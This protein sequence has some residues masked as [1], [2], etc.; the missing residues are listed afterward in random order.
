MDPSSST[1]GNSSIETTIRTL[2]PPAI[3]P[4]NLSPKSIDSSHSRI[5]RIP[6]KNNAAAF[7]A[8]RAAAGKGPTKLKIAPS[9]TLK[10]LVPKTERK[11]QETSDLTTRIR[12]NDFG[13]L[14]ISK[15]GSQGLTVSKVGNNGRIYL[16][17]DLSLT[18]LFVRPTT[19]PTNQR[20]ASQPATLV[21][22]LGSSSL[23]AQNQN[24]DQDQDQSKTRPEKP[25]ASAP[26]SMPETRP[27]HNM[28]NLESEMEKSEGEKTSDLHLSQWESPSP[29]ILDESQTQPKLRHMRNLSKQAETVL[30]GRR[31]AMS[32]SSFHEMPMSPIAASVAV[33]SEPDGLRIVI[34][35]TNER[36]RTA[37]DG[38]LSAKLDIPI[39]SHRIGLPRFTKRGTPVIRTSCYTA[40]DDLQSSSPPTISI[41]P[42]SLARTSFRSPVS[43]YFHGASREPTWM[44]MQPTHRFLPSTPLLPIVSSLAHLAAAQS[45]P[46]TPAEANML[47]TSGKNSSPPIRSTYMSVHQVIEPSMF[48]A[49]TFKPACD[50]RALVR[51]SPISGSVTAATPPRLVAEITSANF[52]DYELLSDFFLTYRAFLE[53]LDLL[54]M[55]IS[56]FRW[57]AA[58]SDE[59]GMVVRVRTFV[60]L[61]HWILN[62]FIDD[63]IN[64]FELRVSF[65]T[66]VNDLIIDLTRIGKDVAPHIKIVNE[67]KKCWRRICAQ[68]WEGPD[69]DTDTDDLPIAPGGSVGPDEEKQ[70]SRLS[71]LSIATVRRELSH[72]ESGVSRV[73]V[74]VEVDDD[75]QL[76][77]P[78][79]EQQLE[80]KQYSARHGVNPLSIS[81]IDVV[82]CTFPTVKSFQKLGLTASSHSNPVRPATAQQTGQSG[83]FSSAP[84][85]ASAPKGIV[86][87]RV[88]PSHKRAGSVS[89]SLRD[90]S[91]PTVNRPTEVSAGENLFPFSG[92]LVRGDL[93]PPSQAFV[94]DNMPTADAEAQRQTTMLETEQAEMLRPEATTAGLSSGTGP[95]VKK[96][97]GS[98]RRALSTRCNP[99]SH[100]NGHS[101]GHG[102]AASNLLNVFGAGTRMPC[103]RTPVTAVVPNVRTK[104]TDDRPAVRVDLLGVEISEAFKRAV[105]EEVSADAAKKGIRLSAALGGPGIQT[106]SP[107]FGGSDCKIDGSNEDNK[108]NNKNNNN[109]NKNKNKNSNNR[110]HDSHGYGQLP[111]FSPSHLNGSFEDLTR[112]STY[113]FTSGR[114]LTHNRGMSDGAITTGS[115]SIMIINDTAMPFNVMA[116]PNQANLSLNSP[117]QAS[118]ISSVLD[119]G[120][121]NSTNSAIDL[122][123]IHSALQMHGV[124]ASVEAFAEALM[125]KNSDLTPPT[126]PPT[127]NNNNNH[128]SSNNNNNNNNHTDQPRRSSLLLNHSYFVRP[129]TD[130]VPIPPFVPDLQGLLDGGCLSPNEAF[131]S[132]QTATFPRAIELA[133]GMTH[134]TPILDFAEGFD[135]SFSAGFGD[136]SFGPGFCSHPFGLGSAS[137]YFGG[138]QPLPSRPMSDGAFSVDAPTVMQNQSRR[139]SVALQSSRRNSV[140]G[141]DGQSIRHSL[142]PSLSDSISPSFASSLSRISG[143]VPPLRILRRRPAGNLRDAQTVE[144]LEPK[145][146][147]YR[148]RSMTTIDTFTD[149][150]GSSSVYSASQISLQPSTYKDSNN[151]PIT[152]SP[153][154]S[155]PTPSIRPKVSASDDEDA[156]VHK[157]LSLFSTHSSLHLRLRPSLEIELRKLAEIPDDLDNGVETALMKLEGR[158][159]RP[160]S[161]AGP[162]PPNAPRLRKM[163]VTLSQLAI[164]NNRNA[165]K[166]KRANRQ[167]GI[168][169]GRL[170]SP[171]TNKSKISLDSISLSTS[172]LR[173]SFLAATSPNRHHQPRRESATSRDSYASVPML[174]RSPLDHPEHDHDHD[175][176]VL[177]PSHDM[178]DHSLHTLDDD[179][180]ISTHKLTGGNAHASFNM[181]PGK[182]EAGVLT[183]RIRISGSFLDDASE[184][185][186]RNSVISSEISASPEI[187]DLIHTGK[188]ASLR[189]A[190]S[191]GTLSAAIPPSPP[192]SL[193][194]S[195]S[196]KAHS[197]HAEPLKQT[198][199]MF[200]HKP[201]PP[202]PDTTPTT[203]YSHGMH[204][205]Q[206]GPSSPLAPAAT[207][208]DNSKEAAHLPFILAFDS[209]ILAQ[210]FTL[211]EKDALIEIDWRELVEM[212][213]K[214]T[215]AGSWRSWLDFLRNSDCHGVEVVVARFNIMVKWA[216]SEI[217]LT[218][219]LEERARCIIKFI[220][221]AK[222]CRRYRN[223]ATLAQITMAL[224]AP[225]VTRLTKTW[226]RVP[227]ADVRIVRDL[228]LLMTPTRNFY[229][230][231]AE[232]ETGSDA[233]CIP[234]VGIYTH[235]LIFNAQR[236]SEIASSPTTG[237]LVNFERYRCAAAVVKTLLRLLEASSLYAFQPIEG[238][239]ERCLW[240]CALSDAELRRRAAKME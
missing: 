53:P 3:T 203:T 12:K 47:S 13:R 164:G 121:V 36:P 33:P 60:A 171:P 8:K 120:A 176:S 32:D 229:N 192:V 106:H 88:R 160:D 24:Q 180:S 20:Y 41:P 131:R 102:N 96:I 213:W 159:Q 193:Q 191:A 22:P 227:A 4:P 28:L 86:G 155:E 219:R 57:A 232:M 128:N 38:P 175:N 123:R 15:P 67:L 100:G 83:G 126:T 204:S 181:I 119:L 78:E 237:P 199:H 179:E 21:A 177:T 111:L 137:Q 104:Q 168:G 30:Q 14:D 114:R 206:S 188:P 129:Q 39:P 239:T 66:L 89:D 45:E 107:G 91:E 81:S 184:C 99:N 68:F 200:A 61:R 90:H 215:T 173:E 157:K 50:D 218:Q 136:Q 186:D 79:L 230:L 197:P 84:K 140:H 49:L 167:I 71:R 236:P 35:Q 98:M 118:G 141:A 222:H 210:Q 103:N 220:H 133:L 233:G 74:E 202:T 127:D 69:F 146:S 165:L 34:S 135:Q 178:T 150:V 40:T 54:R 161:P 37:E 153:S 225:E 51:Y 235:D 10:P 42:P 92:S 87:K 64:D 148:S 56:R 116:L 170:I 80:Q 214:N 23:D 152:L 85:I 149:T 18:K 132:P 29:T 52:L 9:A 144:D 25:P 44:M 169:D 65:C 2:Q 94:D 185:D 105:H 209:D 43:T 17:V 27:S 226:S 139:Q 205:P 108:N 158:Y 196:V 174:D 172:P 151:H 101:N 138:T 198:Q 125:V 194:R 231:R 143:T 224:T 26:I 82:S 59:T 58:R 117:V 77:Q 93:F 48:D 207:D 63:Y 211:I 16:R 201:L 112:Q 19:R 156:S 228:E 154:N 234:F 110:N 115:K 95:A 216:V 166:D 5:R 31:R 162:L 145:L 7:V 1:T 134:E 217:L 73:E 11:P 46:A 55:L 195:Q 223:F 147:M 212:N 208:K 142:A 240:M 221:I 62:Y 183:P 97:F 75:E 182:S 6:S 238:I 189:T 122:G 190:P 109:I 113:G 76:Q 124:N 130:S 163:P 187:L 70:E 72:V